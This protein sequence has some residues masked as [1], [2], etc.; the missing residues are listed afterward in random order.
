[1]ARKTIEERLAQL[2][3]QKKTLQ[4]RLNKQE[5]ARDTR[6][7]V[8]LGALVLHRLEHGKDELS[9]AL[10]DWLR[11]ELPGF[12]TRDMD[13]ELFDDLLAPDGDAARRTES[14]E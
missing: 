7:K 14:G 6:R 8:L 10:P 5:R 13:K 4:A 9:R 12:L 1:M 2:E 3:A 11:R